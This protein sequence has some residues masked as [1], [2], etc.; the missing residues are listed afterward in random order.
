MFLFVTS[1]LYITFSRQHLLS[2]GH[3]S[4]FLQLQNS[5][6]GLGFFGMAPEAGAFTAV[7]GVMVVESVGVVFAVFSDAGGCVGGCVGG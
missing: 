6:F 4:G 1:A 2:T 5:L 7:V 3:S